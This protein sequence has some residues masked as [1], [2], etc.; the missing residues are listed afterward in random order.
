MLSQ[1]P[2]GL[3]ENLIFEKENSLT[4]SQ[5]SRKIIR[6]IQIRQD[7]REGDWFSMAWNGNLERV[8]PKNFR[9][10]FPIRKFS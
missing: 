9:D 10:F 6:D 2:S 7:Y 4:C 8:L 1:K 3:E 5:D